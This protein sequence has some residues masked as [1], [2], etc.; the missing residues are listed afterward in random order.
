MYTKAYNR[1][2]VLILHMGH[3]TELPSYFDFYQH[4]QLIITFSLFA[5]FFKLKMKQQ[6]F[7]RV[8]VF[9]NVLNYDKVE[10]NN[11]LGSFH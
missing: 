8:S 11:P 3:N 1:K 4:K 7:C 2:C 9:I 6:H 5:V 10:M